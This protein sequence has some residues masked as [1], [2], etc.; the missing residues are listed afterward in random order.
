MDVRGYQPPG[1]ISSPGFTIDSH[2][3][4]RV[5][6]HFG[7]ATPTSVAYPAANLAIYIPF[8]LE[9]PAT[10]YETWVETGSLTTSNGTEIGVYT[11]GFAR[12]FHTATTVATA[13]DTVNSSGMT[14]YRLDAGSYYLAFGCDGTRA[15]WASALALGL[16]Q[17]MGIMEQTGL[18]GAV[19]PDPMVPVV[20]TR[21][22][23][24][25]F[26]LNLRADAL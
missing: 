7:T 19:L 18:S 23:L 5:G 25:Q 11:T 24:P 15:F 14:D 6:T 1:V 3:M 13:S 8:V 26:G 22:Y 21:A 20:Y 17:S 4:L 16:Y 9:R 10:V 2:D 12:L